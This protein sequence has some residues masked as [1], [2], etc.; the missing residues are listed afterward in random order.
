MAG[1]PSRAPS[2]SDRPKPIVGLEPL[3]W[4]KSRLDTALARIG[5]TLRQIYER[6]DARGITTAAAADVLAE[7]RLQAR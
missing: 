2:T 4:S 6:A 7:E 3:G 1:V 5:E